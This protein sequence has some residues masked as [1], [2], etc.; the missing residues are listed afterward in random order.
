[1]GPFCVGLVVA[2]LLVLIFYWGFTREHLYGTG[3]RGNSA[4]DD[5]DSRDASLRDRSEA[6]YFRRL[7]TLKTLRDGVS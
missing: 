4:P 1:M 7:Q 3:N 5:V 2:A 6:S